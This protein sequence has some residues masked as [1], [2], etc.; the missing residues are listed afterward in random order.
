MPQS[1]KIGYLDLPSG[2]SGDML[3]GCLMDCGW[4]VERLRQAI[5]SLSLPAS[6][7]AVQVQTVVKGALRA[8]RVDVLADEGRHRRRLADIVAIIRG[9]SLP[10]LVC[11][12]AV[13]VFTRL[14]RAEARV[15]GIAVEQVHFHE[16]GAVDCII[17]IVGSLLGLHELG[18]E[19]LFASPVPLGHGWAQ[20]A[21]GKLPLPAPATLELLSA[22]KIPTRPAP[23]PGEL[24]TPTA[25]A[26][27]AELAV[28]EQPAIELS[29]IGVGAGEREFAWPNIARLW[30]GH[31]TCSD[32]T[33][34]QL[35]TNID[36]MNP[37]L[38][39]EVSDRLFAA[40][41][42]DV[43]V[44]PVQMKKGRPGVVLSVLADSDDEAALCQIVLRQTTTLG[45]RVHPICRRYEATREMRK[46]ATPYGE[47]HVK[48][49][50]L[51]D[52][53]IGAYPE[54][55][56]CKSAAHR[57][58]TTVLAVQEAALA[59]GQSLLEPPANRS[60]PS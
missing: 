17:D 34:V 54:Y 29:R 16:V 44:T 3:L 2:L 58:G 33:L 23:G 24:L 57:A 60:Y 31:A 38:Y 7:W 13:A 26:I 8:T 12:R 40:G 6:E 41:A 28:F 32:V 39:A 45:V 55:E 21:H 25:A 5:Q 51:D 27:L 46:V 48:V 59:A 14:A 56:D 20:T 11:E 4:P 43:W 35:E 22:A 9:G 47:V 50:W 52:E 37:Q 30:I 18:V 36:D 1:G 10:A 49:K 53:A 15:H 42:R 19:K